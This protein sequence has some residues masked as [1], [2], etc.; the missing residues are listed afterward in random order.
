MGL[1]ANFRFRISVTIPPSP[2][3]LPPGERVLKSPSLDGRGQGEGDKHLK[4][5][6]Q[7]LISSR[8][9]GMGVGKFSTASLPLVLFFSAFSATSAVILFHL[10]P[11]L[12]LGTPAVRA[13]PGHST[14][15]D[16][17]TDPAPV[18]GPIDEQGLSFDLLDFDITPETAVL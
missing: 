2:S 3:L 16:L 17:F 10:V 12:R 8:L 7:V 11:W 15:S 13:L 5:L 14:S 18:V 9:I 1:G 6:A 4:S